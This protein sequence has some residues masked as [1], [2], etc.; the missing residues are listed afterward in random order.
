MLFLASF[1][2]IIVEQVLVE[3]CLDMAEPLIFLLFALVKQVADVRHLLRLGFRSRLSHGTA[4]RISALDFGRLSGGFARISQLLVHLG[5]LHS[6][7]SL[8]AD[9]QVQSCDRLSSLADLDVRQANHFGRLGC[10]SLA[11]H[12]QLVHLGG[13][14]GMLAR[15]LL[16]GVDGIVGRD[17][18][19][20]KRALM[21]IHCNMVDKLSR[22]A[23]MV[24]MLPRHQAWL[25][26]AI[27]LKRRQHVLV[28]VIVHVVSIFARLL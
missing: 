15:L 9:L 19:Q 22:N 26:L 12:D 2:L 6:S 20:L 21:G 25:R 18:L 3:H 5:S 14:G 13:I 10:R 23:E 16:L 4:P 8:R 27:R 1:V 11:R 24:T 28:Q 17:R 7:C